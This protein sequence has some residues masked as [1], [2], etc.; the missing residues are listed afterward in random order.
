MPVT[1][2]SLVVEGFVEEFDELLEGSVGLRLVEDRAV[3]CGPAMEGSLVGLA[4]VVAA[5]GFE[6]LLEVGDVFGGHALVLDGVTEVEAGFDLR[7][8]EVGAGWV[9]GFVEVSAVEGGGCGNLAG[10]RG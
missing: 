8:D 5:P 4:L 1:L 6:G 3:G 10:A 9:L 2:K 7:K